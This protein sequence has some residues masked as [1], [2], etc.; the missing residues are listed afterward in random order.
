MPV[1]ARRAGARPARG[2][3]GVAPGREARSPSRLASVP[4]PDHGARAKR[5]SQERIGEQREVVGALIDENVA[6]AKVVVDV[7]G[8]G[9]QLPQPTVR[10]EER[11]AGGV[12]TWLMG[13]EVDVPRWSAETA[14]RE[15]RQ[16]RGRVQ[17]RGLE[18]GPQAWR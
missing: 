13:C 7:T 8:M 17:G 14:K 3:C 9:R 4:P 6:S 12:E 18:L 16:E 1:R 10:G 15:I 5:G 2:C 11:D